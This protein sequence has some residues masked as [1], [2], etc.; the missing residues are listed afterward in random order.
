MRNMKILLARDI[1][2]SMNL[3]VFMVLAVIIVIQ[4]FFDLVG[5]LPGG[6]LDSQIMFFPLFM[7]G[8]FIAI[9]VTFDMIS[10]DREG[11]IMDFILT[12]PVSKPSIVIGKIITIIL[13]MSAF[14]FIYI[15]IGT[16][17][18]YLISKQLFIWESLRL[19]AAME[20]LLVIYGLWG[21]LCS[22]IFRKSKISLFAAIGVSLFLKPQLMNTVATEAGKIIGIPEAQI[23]KGLMLLPEGIMYSILNPANE[24]VNFTWGMGFL[25][26]HLIFLSFM[27]FNIFGRQ[28]ELNYE[29]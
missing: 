20:A 10:R 7:F 25:V 2:N 27:A 1:R 23:T 28:E 13:L 9:V 19:L 12:T 14:S 11:K 15:G 4:L 16:I 24:G 21:F 29:T 8:P 6:S 5:G 26:F 3:R 18:S 22:I 17:V